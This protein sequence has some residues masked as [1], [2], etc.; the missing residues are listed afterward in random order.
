MSIIL[1]IVC[2]QVIY[3][4]CGGFCFEPEVYTTLRRMVVLLQKGTKFVEKPHF[5]HFKVV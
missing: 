2:E 1:G 3:C 4:L 5:S